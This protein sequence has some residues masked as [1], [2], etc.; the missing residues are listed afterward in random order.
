MGIQTIVLHYEDYRDNHSRILDDLLQF[1]ELPRVEQ[2]YPEFEAG[3]EYHEFYTD[4]QRQ[5][6]ANLV[7]EQASLETWQHMKGY[8]FGP[9]LFTALQ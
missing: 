3:K 4:I 9:E 6:V 8:Y 5:A 7:R 1:L 2:H